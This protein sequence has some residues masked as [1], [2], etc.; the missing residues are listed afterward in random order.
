MIM[1]SEAIKYQG[2]RINTPIEAEKNRGSVIVT[3]NN[4]SVKVSDTAIFSAVSLR[5]IPK[6]AALIPTIKTKA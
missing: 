3:S 4:P 5:P 2:I 1:L 6:A